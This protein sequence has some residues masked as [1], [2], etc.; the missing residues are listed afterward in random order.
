[1]KRWTV[2]IV[3]GALLAAAA[4]SSG[5]DDDGTSGVGALP[6]GARAEVES[7]PYEHGSWN[8]DVVDLESGDTLYAND[9]DQL[10]FL[11]S[12][13]KLFTVGAYYDEYGPDHTLET[14]VYASGTRS[15]ATLQGD[16]VLVGK[17][18]FILGGRGVLD[19]PLEYA[20]DYFYPDHVYYYGFPW[21][22]P[23]EADPLAGLD[24]LAAQVVAAGITNID[25]DVLVD[26]KLWEPYEMKEGIVTSIMVND[27]LLDIVVTPGEQAGDPVGMRVIP[28]TSYFEV[29]NQATTSAAGSDPTAASTLGADNQV[30][31]S[32]D[33][34]ADSDPLDLAVFAPDA[35][36]Y[37]R[38]L[39]IEALQRAGVTVGA[40][41]QQ[42]T[43]TLPESSAYSDAN[44]VAALT[45]PKASVLTQLV[46]EV[47]HNRGAE[48]LMCLMAVEAGSRN[49]EDGMATIISKFEKAD[50]EPGTV[51][52]YDGEGTDPASA[53]PAAMIRW[54]T[55]LH[56]QPWGAVLK[57]G[58]P[59]DSG[60][61][62]D[63]TIMMKSGL[64]A[65]PEN[66]KMPSMFIAAG[67][68]GYMTMADGTETIVAVY[69]LNGAYSD[70]AE[71]FYEDLPATVKFV[72]ALQKDG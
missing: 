39:F 59:D 65:A 16:L 58:L 26:D 25:G 46:T 52:I 35:A 22:K 28:E 10:N 2:L 7:A 18:D 34:P 17:G 31:V 24:D 60:D 11:G 9:E 62:G 5:S 3:V 51:M 23:V 40:S 68:A 49:C 21:A 13:T 66:G 48:T 32:G 38:A 6:D 45:S 55:W 67:Q 44:K 57:E 33:L 56:E 36:A 29:V 43:G 20:E 37:A 14:P 69:A 27:N 15:G 19:G 1:M 12:T 53:T 47:S 4:C 50:I 54:L 70:T 8:W 41:V 72:Q 61:T 30:V 42:R 63:A 71:G 64:S